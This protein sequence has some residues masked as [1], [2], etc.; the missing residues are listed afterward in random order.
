MFTFVLIQTNLRGESMK[1][2]KDNFPKHFWPTLMAH[3]A[4]DTFAI[5]I[6]KEDYA[7]KKK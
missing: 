6:R 3:H 4:N 2:Q 5:L 7:R 1:V